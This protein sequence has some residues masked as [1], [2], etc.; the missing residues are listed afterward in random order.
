[1][2]RIWKRLLAVVVAVPAIAALHASPAL[3]GDAG[4]NCQ[5]YYYHANRATGWGFTVCV[6]L[7]HN[8]TAH[9][10]LTSASVTTTTP[11]MTLHS[12]KSVLDLFQD[13]SHFTRE[14]GLIGP[15]ATQILGINTDPQECSGTVAVI[16]RVDEYVTWP[17]GEQS[18]PTTTKTIGDG[19][20][21]TNLTATC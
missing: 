21:G 1:M 11:G 3:A 14:S 9:T 6:K 8:P 4:R 13:T 19:G 18:S 5:T 10:W 16:G 17:S 12:A 15:A 20:V 2:S 7:V